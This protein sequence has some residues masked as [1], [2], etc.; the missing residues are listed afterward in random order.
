[1]LQARGHSW[2]R[3]FSAVFDRNRVDYLRRFSSS[4]LIWCRKATRRF[5]TPSR[6]TLRC[7]RFTRK[8]EDRAIAKDGMKAEG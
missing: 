7:K 3:E 5:N 6:R 8:I 4:L 2:R 1:M